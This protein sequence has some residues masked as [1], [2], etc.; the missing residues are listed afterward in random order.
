MTIVLPT[1]AFQRPYFTTMT[2]TEN[3]RLY[4]LLTLFRNLLHPFV[5]QRTFECFWI[6][7]GWLRAFL[8][9]PPN[10]QPYP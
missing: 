9:C 1:I 4:H 6:M 8:I 7:I 5:V 10:P 3:T 2:T